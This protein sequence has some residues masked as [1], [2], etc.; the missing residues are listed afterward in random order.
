MGPAESQE[1]GDTRVKIPLQSTPRNL[2]TPD[3][4]KITRKYNRVM[5]IFVTKRTDGTKGKGEGKGKD[6]PSL[7]GEPHSQRDALPLG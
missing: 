3:G 4:R 2:T 1:R 7:S 6:L 5:T